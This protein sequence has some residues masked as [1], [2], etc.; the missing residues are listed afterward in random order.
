MAKP[1][2]YV[3]TTVVSY[4][5]SKP[6]KDPIIAGHQQ[7]TQEWWPT[8]G[9]RFEL[10]TTEV[11]TEE[12]RAGDPEMAQERLNALATIPLLGVTDAALQLADA[13]IR[14]GA[15]P[16]KARADALHVAVAATNGM[17]FLVTWNC[18][19]LANAALW[20]KIDEVCQAAGYNPAIICTPELL[21]GD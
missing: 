9:D 2:V 18:K 13:L 1:K 17:D 6:S 21:L 7:T 19:H 4:L 20:R 3:E 14:A 12:A 11:V 8:A 10:W 16:E 15:L 5:T